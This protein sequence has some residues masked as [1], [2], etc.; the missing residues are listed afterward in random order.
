MKKR[1]VIFY[2]KLGKGFLFLLEIRRRRNFSSGNMNQK[3]LF[4]LMETIGDGGYACAGRWRQVLD[5]ILFSYAHVLKTQGQALEKDVDPLKTTFQ[6]I[7][8]QSMIVV[9]NKKAEEFVNLKI[10]NITEGN[11]LHYINYAKR[12]LNEKKRIPPSHHDGSRFLFRKRGSA[13]GGFTEK[14]F[15]RGGF[16][17][18]DPLSQRENLKR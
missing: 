6:N 1:E 16:G 11:R 17:L 7:L 10:N 18:G 13:F 8:A 3:E 12:Y 14:V 2:K 4:A 5:E 9:G 15:E